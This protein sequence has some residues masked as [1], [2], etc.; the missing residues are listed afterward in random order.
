VHLSIADTGLGMEA[1]ILERIFE[2]FF[3]TGDV[4]EGY[5][6]G[7]SVVHGIVSSHKGEIRAF[8]SPG[9]GSVFDVYLPLIPY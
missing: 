7:L 1:E 9:K 5:G 4:G 6:L 8:S 2:P 3:T